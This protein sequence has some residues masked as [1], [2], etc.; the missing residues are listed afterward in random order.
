M[1]AKDAF[2][3]IKSDLDKLLKNGYEFVHTRTLIAAIC[4]QEK[5]APQASQYVELENKTRIADADRQ[6]AS[7]LEVFKSVLELS[8]T[9]LTTAILVN[10]GAAVSLLAFIA[11]ISGKSSGSI[12]TTAVA[13]ALMW[14]VAGVLLSALAT[15]TSYLTQ[16]GYAT[17][18]FSGNKTSVRWTNVGK[19][20]S[21]GLVAI[22][23]LLFGIGAVCAYK[24]FT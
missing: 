9:A 23:Y 21:I 7:N 6:N 13:G 10:G 14:F 2:L 8:K 11:N 18:H 24:A 3:W 16:S 1:E 22:A 4:A 20:A 15:G 5:N 17:A 19:W 12:D